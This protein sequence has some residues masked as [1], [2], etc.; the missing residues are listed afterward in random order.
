VTFEY[1]LYHIKWPTYQHNNL[2]EFYSVD[3]KKHAS[4]KFQIA[5]TKKCEY[6][7]LSISSP[8]TIKNPC[9][10]LAKILHG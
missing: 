6:K 4:K 10:W 8:H 1:V 9:N 5:H 7:N 2:G 3:L